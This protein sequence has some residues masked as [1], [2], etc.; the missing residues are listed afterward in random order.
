MEI[1]LHTLTWN[2]EIMVPFFLRHYENIVDKIFINDNESDDKTVELL[3]AHPKCEISSFNTGGEYRE[4]LNHEI[5]DHAWKKSKGLCDYVIMCDFDEFLYHPNI[6]SF[7]EDVEDLDVDI[8]QPDG[9]EMVAD[10]ESDVGVKVGCG[11]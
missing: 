11:N 1:H 4:L 9:Y 6:H 7:L 10:P 3:S 5:K 2:E 8:V